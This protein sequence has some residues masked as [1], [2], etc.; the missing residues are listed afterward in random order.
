MKFARGLEAV[1][2][3]IDS[4]SYVRVIV[5]ACFRAKKGGV[6]ATPPFTF[7]LALDV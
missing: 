2:V 5:R 7:G 4:L 1:L 3:M 6:C